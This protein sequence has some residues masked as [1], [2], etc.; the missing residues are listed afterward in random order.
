MNNLIDSHV[1]FG[2]ESLKSS[3]SDICKKALENNIERIL[4]INSNIYEFQKDLDLVKGFDFVDISIGHHPNN[5][6][7]ISTREIES[8]LIENINKFEDK[9]VGIGETG[10]DY[11]YEVPKNRQ[12]ESF[13]THLD[14]ATNFKLPCIIHM[15]DAEKD[16][17]NILE[18]YHKKLDKIL[19]HCFT[20]SKEFAKKCIDL[21]C[22]FSL[23]GIITF[24]NA[25]KL[26]DIIKILPIERVIF[27]TDS[28]YLTPDPFRGKINNPMYLKIILEKYCE[29]T[30]NNFAKIC[31][32]STN[33]Y[34][35]LFKIHV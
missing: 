2:H 8:I 20:G 30:G 11:H 12:I 3:V 14:V 19:I 35:K 29:I 16:M 18:K 21:N 34:K 6:S 24:K 32:I 28:P 5:T 7:N 17:I 15:R 23:S 4:S 26:R 1:N 22:Y 31:K 9:I 27:E 25:D 10:L 13:E 33:N